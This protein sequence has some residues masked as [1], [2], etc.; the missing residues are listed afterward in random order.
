MLRTPKRYSLHL[1]LG[2]MI[3]LG[4]WPSDYDDD[5]DYYDKDDDDHDD[6]KMVVLLH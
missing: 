4:L 2:P 1:Y 6:D 5:N 3:P